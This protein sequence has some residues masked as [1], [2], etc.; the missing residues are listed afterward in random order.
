MTYTFSMPR[1]ARF[2][3][4]TSAS[5]WSI[6]FHFYSFSAIRTWTCSLTHIVF[7]LT[8]TTLSRRLY[9]T[10]LL[11]CHPSPHH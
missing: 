5:M 3:P 1:R 6:H 9:K 11:R 7:Q 10:P 8:Q 2:P 4:L